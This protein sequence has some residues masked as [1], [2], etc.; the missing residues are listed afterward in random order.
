M[1]DHTRI[2][3]LGSRTYA[4]NQSVPPSKREKLS[5]DI[6]VLTFL[7]FCASPSPNILFSRKAV[8]SI[9]LGG[10][11]LRKISHSAFL[12]CEIFLRDRK[13]GSEEAFSFVSGT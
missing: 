9:A 12:F 5:R 10:T 4:A 6:N 2:D 13:L 11:K 3:R 7:Y 8:T 1:R